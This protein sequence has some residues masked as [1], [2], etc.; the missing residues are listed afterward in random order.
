M[1]KQEYLFADF[2][3]GQKFPAVQYTVSSQEAD[4]FLTTYEHSQVRDAQ[5]HVLSDVQKS[6]AV[7]PVHPLLAGSFQLQ[8]AVF[9]WPF[10]VLHARE[11]ITLHKPV[12]AGEPLE[13]MLEVKNKF[14]KNDKKFLIIQIEIRKVEGKYHALTVERTLVWPN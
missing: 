2:Q 4:K 14:I 9:G 11:K 5:G 3:I 13:A 8:H 1:D 7:R 12:Y 10:G 6:A